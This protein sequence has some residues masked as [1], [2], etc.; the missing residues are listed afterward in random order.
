MTTVSRRLCAGVLVS[1]LLASSGV[2]AGA[3][4]ASEREEVRQ[5]KAVLSGE[6]DHLE[7]SDAVLVD[8]LEELEGQLAGQRAAVR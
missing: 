3:D 2:A 5:R 6:L 4:P 1:M 7:A 8:A